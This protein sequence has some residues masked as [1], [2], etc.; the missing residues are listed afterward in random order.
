[1]ILEVAVGLA[2]V[3]AIMGKAYGPA[4]TVIFMLC[5]IAATYTGYNLFR[6]IGSLRDPTIDVQ[7]RLQDERRDALE[8]EKR[9]LLQGIKELEV[10]YGVGKVDAR[11]YESL[12]RTAE[13]R[14]LKIIAELR[15]DDVQW[16]ERATDLIASKV[17]GIVESPASSPVS[18]PP[19]A[20]AEP[21]VPAEA[22]VG[23][24]RAKPAGLFDDRPAVWRPEGDRF[25]CSACGTL[26]DPDG[27]FCHGCGRPRALETK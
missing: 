8:Y 26:N 11:D 17:P 6:M 22:D 18:D 3:A 5:G 2:V 20:A 9:L 16:K 24:E 25:A 13:N 19:P 1:M 15:R 7:G 21:I 23:P 12:R 27:R 4:P 10:D 14:A